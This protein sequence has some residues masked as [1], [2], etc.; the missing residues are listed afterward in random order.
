MAKDR[1]TPLDTSFLIGEDESTNLCV[2]AVEVLAGPAPSYE[3]VVEAIEP[4]LDEL[5]RFRQRLATVPLGLGRPRWVDD[6]HFRITNH[7][8]HAAVPAP[9]GP[10]QLQTLFAG[11]IS[12]HMRR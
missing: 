6:P 2:G 4:R 9:G 10:S 11:F 5:P 12:E 7:V 3:E 8:R 1:L